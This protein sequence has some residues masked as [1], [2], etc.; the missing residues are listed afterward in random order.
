MDTH[1]NSRSRV[2][3]LSSERLGD[4]TANHRLIQLSLMATLTL[5]QVGS[6]RLVTE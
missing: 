4:F 1:T 6:P 5:E 2:S 3:G